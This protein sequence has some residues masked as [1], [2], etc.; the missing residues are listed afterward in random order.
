MSSNT[1]IEL[2][3]VSKYYDAVLAVDEVS[4]TIDGGTICALPGAGA[5]L[6]AFNS[7]RQRGLL[8]HVGE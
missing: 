5:F 7:A 2:Q 4:F 1:A 8:L 6:L 3:A